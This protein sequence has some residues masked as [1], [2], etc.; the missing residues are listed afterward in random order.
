MR[1][2]F[3]PQHF[4][5]SNQTT[6]VA[7]RTL[8]ARGAGDRQQPFRRD[9]TVGLVDAGRDQVGDRVEIAWSRTAWRWAAGLTAFHDTLNGLVAGAAKL[10]GCAIG[11][12]W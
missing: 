4:L 5:L 7:G 3:A 12:T 6:K 8:I 1:V 11:P 2:L 9:P 10:G